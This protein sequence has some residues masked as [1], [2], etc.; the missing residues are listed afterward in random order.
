MAWRAFWSAGSPLLRNAAAASLVAL[1]FLLAGDLFLTQPQRGAAPGATGRPA[2]EVALVVTPTQSA[3]IAPTPV[4]AAAEQETVVDQPAASAAEPTVTQAL[5]AVAEPTATPADL[6]ALDVAP[7]P[8][9]QHT[10]LPS[11]GAMRPPGPDEGM[12]L[13]PEGTGSAL[14]SEGREPGPAIAASADGELMTAASAANEAPETATVGQA[15]IESAS[16]VATVATAD[17]AAPAADTN[18]TVVTQTIETETETLSLVAPISATVAPSA[19]LAATD[20]VTTTI[21]TTTVVTT[22]TVSTALPSQEGAAMPT[23]LSPQAKTPTVSGDA[24]PSPGTAA[25]V[26]VLSLLKIFQISLAFLALLFG[27]LWW[28]SR[29]T[30]SKAA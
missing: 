28:R 13:A 16:A 30:S 12:E 24:L 9:P 23:S 11:T 20:V 3:V 4:A 26:G 14:F 25:Q 21:M 17:D 19:L 29:A 6:L 22:T 7:S 1:L 18:I 2:A 10:L 5:E 15:I 8:A 27:M